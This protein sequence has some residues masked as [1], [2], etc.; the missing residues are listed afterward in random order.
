[1]KRAST[2]MLLGGLAGLMGFSLYLAIARIYQVDECDELICA[3]VV[4]MGHANTYAG[5]IGLLAF[6]LAWAVHGAARSVDFFTA[7]RLVRS[8]EHTSELQSLRHFVCRL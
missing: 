8:G 4:A 5:T 3:R 6:P 2:W 1:M 7:G